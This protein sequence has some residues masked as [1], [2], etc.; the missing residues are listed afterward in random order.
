MEVLKQIYPKS[1]SLS[2]ANSPLASKIGVLDKV[3]HKP[4]YSI[5]IHDGNKQQ[6]SLS[7]GKVTDF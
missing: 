2:N 4:N 5:L 1:M 7:N 3:I 6:L